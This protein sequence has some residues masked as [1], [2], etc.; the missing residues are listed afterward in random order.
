ME[1]VVVILAV[2]RVGSNPARR[3]GLCGVIRP[4][5]CILWCATQV[6]EIQ[7]NRSSFF[8]LLCISCVALAAHPGVEPGLQ[9]SKPCGLPLAQCAVRA[10]L[11]FYAYEP[12]SFYGNHTIIIRRHGRVWS[13]EAVVSRHTSADVPMASG[14]ASASSTRH[15]WHYRSSRAGVYAAF[16]SITARIPLAVR[17]S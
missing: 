11:P 6:G 7:R 10:V 9:G 8:T 12:Q 2:R 15:M 13:R 5:A 17:I 1:S 3:Y 16:L 14:L 4:W